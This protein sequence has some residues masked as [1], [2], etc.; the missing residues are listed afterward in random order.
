MLAECESGRDSS[1]QSL[2]DSDL[3]SQKS[4]QKTFWRQIFCSRCPC[5]WPWLPIMRFRFAHFSLLMR[6]QERGSAISSILKRNHSGRNRNLACNIPI[7]LAKN[8][9]KKCFDGKTF[10]L[11]APVDGLDCPSRAL[12]LLIFFFCSAI[13][14][15]RLPF[16]SDAFAYLRRQMPFENHRLRVCRRE[17]PVFLLG[18][19]FFGWFYTEI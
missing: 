6:N 7:C 11:A 13:R 17:I 18:F 15:E 12:D 2:Q 5:W 8:R 4:P 10:A 16:K 3:F 19:R 9:R 14:R 1:E